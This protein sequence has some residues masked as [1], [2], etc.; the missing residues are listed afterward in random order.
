MTE[1]SFNKTE[2]SHEMN[3][4]ANTIDQANVN[5]QSNM[6]LSAHSVITQSHYRI[7]FT[8]TNTE[9]EMGGHE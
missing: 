4:Q 8:D 9:E 6:T 2:K 1:N 5:H 7:Q 3:M